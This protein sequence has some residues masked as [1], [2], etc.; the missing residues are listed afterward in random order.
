VI[1]STASSL[2][3]WP[4]SIVE[5]RVRVISD[6]D[7]SGDP[8]GSVQLA[9][10]LLSPSVD[11][12]CVIGSHLRAGDPFDSS[13][14]TA[15]K[16]A[17]IAQEVAIKCHRTDVRVVAGSNTSLVDRLT[18]IRSE[19]AL[20]MVNE[21]MR[22][23]DNRPLFVVCGAGLT[24]IASAWLIEPGIA[25]R[26]TLIWIGGHE[27][28]DLAEAAPG[29]PDMEYNLHIDPI[30][31]QVVFNDSN[32]NVWQ[33]PRDMYRSVIASRAELLVRMHS[34]GHLGRYLFNAVAAAVEKVTSHGRQM[35]ETYVLGD[36][37]LVLLTALTTAFEP[38][39]ASSFY[40]TIPCPR[41]LDSGLYEPRPNGRPL[42][43]FTQLDNRTLLEDL[44]A[45]LILHEINSGQL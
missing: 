1:T 32:L 23:D 7:Y 14:T 36:S 40:V 27:H 35:G 3:G 20:I 18:P 11:M 39:P 31:G 43:V 42:R 38:G 41:I 17:V 28:D 13:A 34:A 37:P 25:E 26:L 8:D 33:V 16:A 29:A 4:V 12:R 10:H 45:K 6:N 15:D 9:Q 21:A 22:A 30:A 44:Y 19:A 24:E 5:P 2:T